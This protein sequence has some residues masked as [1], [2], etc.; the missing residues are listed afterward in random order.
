MQP[1][2]FAEGAWFAQPSYVVPV[3]TVLR[4]MLLGI[5]SAR[6]VSRGRETKASRLYGYVTSA[7]FRNRMA[8]LVEQVLMMQ[9]SLEQERRAMTRIWAAR[10]QQ[11]ERALLATAGLFGDVQGLVGSELKPPAA[12]RLEPPEVVPRGN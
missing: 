3:V 2:E 4:H 9:Q 10:S 7:E 12:L 5:A 8:G 11:L 1:F 6:E